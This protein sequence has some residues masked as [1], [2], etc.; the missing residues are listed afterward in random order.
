MSGNETMRKT[1]ILSCLIGTCCVAFFC[2]TS[3]AGQ[4]GNAM[5]AGVKT[6]TARST[7]AK[8]YR[9][10]MA[11]AGALTVPM[12][13]WCIRL[14]K[15]I[16]SADTQLTELDDAMALISTN[17]DQLITYIDTNSDKI[18]T[19]SQE[20]VDTFNGKINQHSTNIKEYNAL[21]NQRN[22]DY[23]VYVGLHSTFK[24]ECAS[25]EYYEEDYKRAVKNVGYG[26]RR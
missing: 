25:E 11:G 16:A 8:A 23:N 1:M 9:S 17:I 18:D 7:A 21:L 24:Q 5:G 4:S 22:S 20:A 12:L 14:E 26:L 3:N 6:V 10:T 19:T 15:K 13:E 2:I